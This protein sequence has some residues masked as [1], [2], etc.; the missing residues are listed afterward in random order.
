SILQNAQLIDALGHE[1]PFPATLDLEPLPV[2]VVVSAEDADRIEKSLLAATVEARERIVVQGAHVSRL[3][4]ISLDIINNDL[5]P[6]SA[7]VFQTTQAQSA[8]SRL[9]PTGINALKIPASGLVVDKPGQTSVTMLDE[10]TSATVTTEIRHHL[11]SLPRIDSQ[12]SS[13][14]QAL[15]RIAAPVVLAQR[16][17]VLPAD[18]GV[19]WKGADDLSLTAWAGWTPDGIALAVHVKDDIHIGPPSGVTHLW[20]FDSLQ[21]AFDPGNRAGHGYDDH[22]REFS[23]ALDDA[24]APVIVDGSGV[25]ISFPPGQ[26]RIRKDGTFVCYEVLFPWSRL[27]DHPLSEGDAFRMNFIAND[28]DGATRKC[29]I[30]L[31]PG[32]GEAKQPAAFH[33]WIL[34]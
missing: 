21:V 10:R 24:G 1:M 28:R 32:I 26:L 3:D 15:R 16:D 20:G 31:T 18:P 17:H 30:G 12:A 25:R 14:E 11:R 34:R 23:L 29:W 4:Q 2:F 6:V 8:R 19:D 33:Q 22:C 5:R 7:K 27:G 13:L 9:L